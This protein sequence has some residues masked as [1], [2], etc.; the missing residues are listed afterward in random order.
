MIQW[1]NKIILTRSSYNISAELAQ[2]LACLPLIRPARDRIPAG[3]GILIEQLIK[4]SNPETRRSGG[5][6]LLITKLCTKFTWV[7]SRTPPQ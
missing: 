7:K 4:I 2:W 5:V 3:L 6:Q 1:L